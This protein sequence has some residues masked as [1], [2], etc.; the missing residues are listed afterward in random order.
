MEYSC[1]I[2]YRR[3][4]EIS[5]F[6]NKLKKLIEP[7][8]FSVTNKQN[9]FFDEKS[10]TWGKDFDDKI[11]DGIVQSYFFI[12]LY[13][14]VYLHED[15]LWCARELHWAIQFEN[16]I[17]EKIS[18]YCF[19]LP[20]IARGS[21]SD[22]PDCIGRKNAKEIKR[23]R[24]LIV[25]GGTSKKFEEFKES[26]YDIFLENYDLIST[27]NSFVEYIDDITPISD[28]ELIEWIKEQKSKDRKLSKGRLPIIT[29][30]DN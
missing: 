4:N 2:S 28:E 24:H 1:F 5:R 13:H 29:K 6:M 30:K 15:N 22:F 10:I 27:T 19:I 25:S 18:N 16:K 21:A 14:N 9:V 20:L 7:L 12:P 23:F 17:R 26:I 11:Y 8:A 3:H